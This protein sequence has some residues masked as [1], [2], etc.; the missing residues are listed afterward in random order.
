MH[1][2][3]IIILSLIL[4]SVNIKS[5]AGY[6]S[7]DTKDTSAWIEKINSINRIYFND[8]CKK[9]VTIDSLKN[10]EMYFINVESNGCSHG[11]NLYLTIS[12]T[13]NSYYAAFR[14]A[15]KI[16]GEKVK[17][18]FGRTKLI[19]AQIDS[20]RI[21][22]NELIRISSKEYN[23]TTIDTYSLIINGNKSDYKIDYCD[24]KMNIGK[25]TWILFKQNST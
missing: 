5:I 14:M 7:K 21:F 19:E 16:E 13:G 25:L 2:N 11:T 4:L 10:G 12:K 23:C 18:K 22:E 3:R 8:S 6:N 20:I 24:W 9:T 15:G 17:K 1:W